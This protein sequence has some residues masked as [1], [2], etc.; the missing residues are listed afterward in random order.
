MKRI[1]NI[2]AALLG[3]HVFLSAQYIYPDQPLGDRIE[4]QSFFF[5]P[6]YMNPYGVEE[7]S[8][9]LPGV[10]DHPLMNIQYNPSMI[11]SIGNESKI[12][13]DYRTNKKIAPQYYYLMPWDNMPVILESSMIVPP[14]PYYPVNPR[15][16]IE[17]AFS[18]AILGKPFPKTIPELSL[19]VS[20]ELI[21]QSEPHYPLDVQNPYLM[22][23]SDV[24]TNGTYYGVDY[25]RNKGHLFALYSGYQLSSSTSVGLRIGGT[26]FKRDAERGPNGT[27]YNYTTSRSQSYFDDKRGQEHTLFD[28]TTGVQWNAT[29]HISFGVTAGYLY[30]TFTQ[31]EQYQNSYESFSLN[32]TNT[33]YFSS[34]SSLFDRKWKNNGNGWTA[35]LHTSVILSPV[36]KLIGTYS[37]RTHLLHLTMH[38]DDF[39]NSSYTDNT[40]SSQYFNSNRND[41]SRSGNGREYLYYHRASAA[42]VLKTEKNVRL[43]IGVVYTSSTTF[44]NTYEDINAATENASQN[45]QQPYEQNLTLQNKYMLWDFDELRSETQIPLMLTIPLSAMFDL[46][47]GINR[48]FITTETKQSTFSHYNRIEKYKNNLLESVEENKNMVNRYP[49][50]QTETNAMAVL[51]GF[52]IRPVELLNIH[53]SGVP[54]SVNEDVYFQWMAGI[55]ITP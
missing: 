1:F 37:H 22:R 49:T 54:Y 55:N 32:G 17:P 15:L 11:T 33:D 19:G 43:S 12:F 30:G 3:I 53:I 24:S 23:T 27:E 8:T 25:V 42:Y 41:E 18:S 28:L 47:F 2:T 46:N 38:A 20:Y 39:A 48:R 4:Q 13:I 9:A 31:R 10:I 21:S 14:Y 50:Q 51:I 6:N 7:F 45:I 16:S 44:R 35:G 26:L 34:S 40:R 52:S 5:T 29:D 36:S